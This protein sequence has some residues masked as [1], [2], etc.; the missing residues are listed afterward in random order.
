[1]VTRARHVLAG[2]ALPGP[3]A[4]LGARWD[5]EGTNFALWS[6][7]AE[8]VDLC[9][10]DADGTEHRQPLR[11]DHPP[12]LARLPARG[13]PGPALRLPGARPLRP[14]GRA[15]A[16]TRP[17]CCSTRTRGR[18]TAA[19]TLHPA[20]FGYA[21]DAVDSAARDD[22]DSAP[23]VPRSSS[24]TTPSRGTATGRRAPRGRTPSSTSCTSRAPPRATRTCRRTLRGTYAGPGAPG[25]VEHLQRLGVTA[26]E[27][28]PVHHFVTEPHLLRRGLTNYWGY[29]TLGYFAPH[30]ALQLRGQRRRPGRASS[31]RWSGRCTRPASR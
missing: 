6:A 18:S 3:P 2:E 13:R 9:L 14:A 28:L 15:A 17:S 29:N 5:G 4:P 31:R 7:G 19:L 24:S 12:R 8:A 26:V 27:L 10:F 20:L 16:T 22:R 23:Y 21:G 1:M 11:G 25:V 30:A